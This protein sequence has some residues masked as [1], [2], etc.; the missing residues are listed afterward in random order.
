MRNDKGI[1]NRGKILI[2]DDEQGIIDALRVVL[3]R[4]GFEID[5]TTNTFEAIEK[6]KN[7]NY[8]MLILDFYL[9]ENTADNII[10]MIRTFSHICIILLT[11]Y[12]QSLPPI[13]TL[14]QY[15][16]QSFCCK[17]SDFSN[18]LLQVETVVKMKKYFLNE[19]FHNITIKEMMPKLRESHGETQISL[20]KAVGI[21]RG[22]IID[23]ESG[24]ST[25]SYLTLCKLANHWGITI[26]FLVGRFSVNKKSIM[27]G[28]TYI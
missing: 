12:T 13:K 28:D 5:G 26:D 9:K 11:G 7:N 16:I 15:D 22:T 1:K 18:I 20:A 27:S 19:L 25:P 24:A 6:I 8:E 2:H 4:E 21:H 14:Q 23:I 3:E 10:K 17:D